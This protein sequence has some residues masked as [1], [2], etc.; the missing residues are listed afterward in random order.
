VGITGIFLMMV[1][2]QLE[3]DIVITA[4]AWFLSQKADKS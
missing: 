3:K 1:Q 2:T 4:F